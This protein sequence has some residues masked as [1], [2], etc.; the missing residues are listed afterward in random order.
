MAHKFYQFDYA[1]MQG[2]EIVNLGILYIETEKLVTRDM[3]KEFTK[4]HLDNPAANI[5]ISNVI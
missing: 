4:E 5:L 3:L 1:E 2:H